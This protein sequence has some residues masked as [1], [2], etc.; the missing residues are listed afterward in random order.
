MK[1]GR[2]HMR[3][4]SFQEVLEVPLVVAPPVVKDTGRLTRTQDLFHL[5]LSIANVTPRRGDELAP[6]ELLLGERYY[7]TYLNGRFKSVVR[8]RDG[9]LHLFD[10]ERDPRERRNVAESHPDVARRHLERMEELL[11]GL[12]AE[13][14]GVDKLSQRD[15]ARLRALGYLA[16]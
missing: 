14:T 1:G 15:R 10:L 16:E 7:R 11:R 6:D 2:D 8:R 9:E 4:P 12:G 5:V 3:N 13:P